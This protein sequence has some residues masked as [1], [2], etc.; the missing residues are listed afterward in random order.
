MIPGLTEDNLNLLRKL[1]A[2]RGWLQRLAGTDERLHALRQLEASGQVAAIFPLFQLLD[3]HDEKFVLAVVA[4]M[5][6]LFQRLAPQD[7][8][9]FDENVRQASWS[10]WTPGG[11]TVVQS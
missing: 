4:C 5:H 1:S 2:R 8:P 9:S 3:F 10:S 11:Y 7:F 6:S